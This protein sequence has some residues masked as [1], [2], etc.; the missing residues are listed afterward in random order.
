MSPR[1]QYHSSTLKMEAGVSSETSVQ[2]ALT[3]RWLTLL[4]NSSKDLLNNCVILSL[5]TASVPSFGYT[6]AHAHTHTHRGISIF[7]SKMS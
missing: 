4:K 5:T 1:S 3:F 7:S 2:E 6:Q